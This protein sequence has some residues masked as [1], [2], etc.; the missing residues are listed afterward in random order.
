MGIVS[1]KS[2]IFRGVERRSRIAY[3]REP[4]PRSSRRAKRRRAIEV[5]G[6]GCAEGFDLDHT[7]STVPA[8]ALPRGRGA[9]ARLAFTAKCRYSNGICRS[10]D[11]AKV[12]SN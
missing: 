9:D 7:P 3:S 11:Q 10:R 2:W 5:M 8:L 12:E 6:D 4:R 1:R